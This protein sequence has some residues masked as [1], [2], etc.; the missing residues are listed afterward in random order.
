MASTVYEKGKIKVVWIEDNPLKIYSK[1]FDKEKDAKDF[2]QKKK[3]Y[4]IFALERQENMQEFS[5]KL[6][7]Y[8]KYRIYLN[9]VKTLG[10]GAG[11]FKQM[12][13]FLTS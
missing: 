3:D 10:S 12:R 9:L 7:P 2:G 11:V 1:M 5:W 13:N 8:G 4:L 6:L